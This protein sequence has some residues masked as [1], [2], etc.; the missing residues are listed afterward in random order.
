MASVRKVASP[1]KVVILAFAFGMTFLMLWMIRDFLRPM[2]LGAIFAG[3]LHPTYLW[4]LDRVGK[5]WLASGITV[6]GVSVLLL[7]FGGV[8]AAVAAQQAVE[9]SDR[10][11][12]EVTKQLE[13]SS[14]DQGLEWIERQVPSLAKLLPTPEVAAQKLGEAGGA[15]ANLLVRKAS[16]LTVGLAGFLLELFIMGYA[17]YFYLIHGTTILRRVKKLIPMTESNK[18]RVLRRFVVVTRSTLKGTLLIGL[19]QGGLN[20]AALAVAGVGSPVFLGLLMVVFSL[21]PGIGT[22]LVWGPVVILAYIRGEWMTGTLLLVWCGGVVGSLDNL[23]RPKLVGKAAKLPDLLVL[24][25]TLGGI[26]MFGMMGFIVGPVICSLYVI[27][28]EILGVVFRPA[29]NSPA[30]EAGAAG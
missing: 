6:M 13:H 25:G 8:L 2:F 7:G 29:S 26:M 14:V 4:W 19:I 5:P 28:W 21:L 30:A 16:D 22:A 15:L 17:M 3:L 18:N 20:G 9:M 23:L 12:P 27:S 1:R 10:V 24:V 11:M